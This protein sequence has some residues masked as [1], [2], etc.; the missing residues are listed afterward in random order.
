MFVWRLPLLRRKY[1]AYC[2]MCMS[3]CQICFSQNGYKSKTFK[4]LNC[5]KI[6]VMRIVSYW[7][8]LIKIFFQKNPSLI[9][10]FWGNIYTSLSKNMLYFCRRFIL[11]HQYPHIRPL[12]KL[13][14][15]ISSATE[16]VTKYYQVFDFDSINNKAFMF[17]MMYYIDS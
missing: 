4:S 12:V 13:T 10:V 7:F 8:L 11:L 16:N 9:L 3:V 15:K 1:S 2:P 5:L 14:F 6:S 17:Q